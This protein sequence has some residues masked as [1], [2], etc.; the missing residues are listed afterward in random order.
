MRP[1][2]EKLLEG[3]EEA[4]YKFGMLL[5]PAPEGKPLPSRG[6]VRIAWYLRFITW[7]LKRY[8]NLMPAIIQN[9]TRGSLGGSPRNAT[10]ELRIDP[11]TG[12]RILHEEG[13]YIVNP[14]CGHCP[15]GKDLP[16][17]LVSITASRV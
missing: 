11:V 14:N 17:R 7:Y 2:L 10:V 16:V 5:R 13:D 9:S 8:P 1:R 6:G 12:A 3:K 4:L 15:P